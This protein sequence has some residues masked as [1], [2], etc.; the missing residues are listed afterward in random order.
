[1]RIFIDLDG[2]LA[3][4]DGHYARHYGAVPDRSTREPAAFWKNIAEHPGGF[5]RRMPLMPDARVLWDAV[6][7]LNPVILTGVPI[8]V[9]D[10]AAQKRAWVAEHFPGT[11]VITTTSRE[12][13]FYGRPG[14]VLV[15][16]WAKYRGLWESMGGTFVLHVSAENS[17][18]ELEK[19]VIK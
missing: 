1:M 8:S 17:L 11:R 2:V 15:D 13:R 5:F 6:K 19:L 12:K 4:F 10:A 7:H 14:D 9:Y 3:D 16:D 18:R